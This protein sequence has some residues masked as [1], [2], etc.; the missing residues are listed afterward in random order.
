MTEGLDSS[1]QERF[2]QVVA[3]YLEADKLGHPPERESLLKEFPELENELREFFADHDRMNKFA[4]PLRPAHHA[5]APQE[6][7]ARTLNHVASGDQSDPEHLAITFPDDV[8]S[9]AA[10]RRQSAPPVG[11]RVRYFGDYELLDEVARGG[12]G[13]VYKAR[14]VKLNRIV[15]LKMI[16]AGQFAS[17]EDVQRFYTE[18]E[19]AANLDHPGIVPIFEV[20]EFEGQ[21]YLSMGFVDGESLASKLIEGPL[22]PR[23]A[24]ELLRTVVQ[25]VQFAHENGVIHRD[26]KPSNILLD[27]QCH[28]RITDFG[29]AKRIKA[30]RHVTDTGQILGTPSFMPPEQA[31]GRL[32]QVRETS[33]VYALG[34]ILYTSL[35]GHPPF[36]ADNPLDTLLQVMEREPISPRELNQTVPRDLETICLKCL[37]KDRRRRY[38]SAQELGDELERYSDGRPIQARPI[39]RAARVWRWC[40]R[41]PIVAGLMAALLAVVVAGFAAVSSQW[42]RAEQFARLE[43]DA[44]EK[45]EAETSRAEKLAQLEKNARQEAEAEATRAE[46]ERDR[47]DRE[48]ARALLAARDSREAATRADMAAEE[49]RAYLYAARMNL[50]QQAWNDGH[51]DRVR[52]ILEAVKPADGRIDRRGFEWS[53][54]AR[55]C[56]SDLASFA[57]DFGV[58]D[59][60]F[61]SDGQLLAASVYEQVRVWSVSEK[62]LIHQ[63][64]MKGVAQCVAFSSDGRKVAS[65]EGKGN[66]GYV[67]TILVWDVIS[68]KKTQLAK[69]NGSVDQL[70]FSPDG[71]LIAAPVRY[72]PFQSIGLKEKEIPLAEIKVWQLNDG[73]ELY[74]I[75]FKIPNP[76]DPRKMFEAAYLAPVYRVAFSPDGALLA[77]VN[78]FANGNVK[79]WDAADGHELLELEGG[80]AHVVFSPDG[81]TITSGGTTWNV[82]DGRIVSSLRPCAASDA[83]RAAAV[84]G[85]GITVWDVETQEDISKIRGYASKLAISPDGW[86]MA[87]AGSKGIQIWDAQANQESISLRHV[88]SDPRVVGSPRVNRV[89]LSPDGRRIVTAAFGGLQGGMPLQPARIRVWDRISGQQLLD[90]SDSSNHCTNLEFNP[91][92]KLIAAAFFGEGTVLWNSRS[93][94][95]LHRFKNEGRHAVFSPDGKT[96]ATAGGEDRQPQEVVLRNVS[97][98]KVIRRLPE[99]WYAISRLAFSPDGLQ[100]AVTANKDRTEPGPRV[101]GSVTVWEVANGRQLKSSLGPIENMAYS[102]DGELL[103]TGSRSEV[104]VFHARTLDEVATLDE[105]A[106]HIAFGPDSRRLLTGGSGVI[107]VWDVDS[108]QEVFGFR[109][110]GLSF[111]IGSG[112]LVSGGGGGPKI[113]DLRPTSTEDALEREAIG[114]AQFLIGQRLTAEETAKRIRDDKTVSDEVKNKVRSLLTRPNHSN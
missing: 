71:T 27:A 105:P 102:P 62:E 34:A 112:F 83:K 87:S 64:K 38:R 54:L 86:R 72:S 90:I 29:L 33:D 101:T 59:L 3:E 46:A 39:G 84:D 94:E 58:K 107:R 50:A 30:D 99:T 76:K 8:R 78:A 25:A 65:A 47:A 114:F 15:A 92:G 42:I 14:Q 21:H 95:L 103:A 67:S 16:L 80:A 6:P 40:C 75:V 96:I 68:G 9:E 4:Q 7:D 77:G 97:T 66:L 53:Y 56:D 11:T 10:G 109:G 113:W 19:S 61:N 37:E 69:C 89:A 44:R 12:M 48:A 41:K 26:L 106:R 85:K 51:I 5:S 43:A 60:V 23:E 35:T 108:W 73:E 13:V 104:K 91:D 70:A 52:Q 111:D 36:H 100:L 110:A 93:G 88:A 81:R 45:A 2:N 22:P 18:A 49:T 20:G 57:M 63:F 82:S 17:P 79:L 55:L 28:P 98:G 1:R 74:S 31:A 32:D 24:A